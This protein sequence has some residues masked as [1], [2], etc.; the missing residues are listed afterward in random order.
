MTND[1]FLRAHT[2]YVRKPRGEPPNRGP[3]NWPDRAL[4]FD[5]ETRTDT[6]Q[7]LT[8]GVYRLCR[9]RGDVYETEAEGLFYG[10]DVSAHECDVLDAYVRSSDH[11]PDV[12][13]KTFPPKLRLPLY[14]RAMFIE[15]V[16]WKAIQR[17]ALVVG[18]NLKF[19]L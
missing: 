5:C 12:T 15:Q 6:A 10:G 11:H 14:S 8:L 3:K 16:F 19:D 1:L 7:R 9:L 4:I 13:V 18:F 17:G 2:T